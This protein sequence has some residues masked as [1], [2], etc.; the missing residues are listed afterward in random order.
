MARTPFATFRISPLFVSATKMFPAASTA[1][2]PGLL[3]AALA[4]TTETATPPDTFLTPLSY[5]SEMYRLP[6][7]S[8][9]SGGSVHQIEIE[10]IGPAG[11]RNCVDHPMSHLPNLSTAPVGDVQCPV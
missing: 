9:A 8:I 2:P 7:E 3:N 4:T 11:P 10:V 6:D 1:T 5:G